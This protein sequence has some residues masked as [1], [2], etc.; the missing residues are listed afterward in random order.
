MSVHAPSTKVV[1]RVGDIVGPL[2][3]LAALVS[4][5][6]LALALPAMKAAPHDLPV[7]IAGPAV[8]AGPVSQQLATGQPGAVSLTSFP[9]EAALRSAITHREVYGGLLLSPAGPKLLVASAASPTVAI[10]LQSL[11]QGIAQAQGAQLTV[12]DVVPLPADDPHGA[13]L[14]AALLPMLIGAV[15]TVAVSIRIVRGPVIRI[16]AALAANLAVGFGVVAVL[17]FGLGALTGS[18]PAESLTL[19][20]TLAA[21]SMVL[22]GLFGLIRWP[23]VGLGVLTMLLLGMPLSGVQGAPELLPH[24]WAT[25]GQ[26]LPPGAGG[27]ALRSVAYFDGHGALAALTVLGCWAA[28]GL[29]L[30]VGT[31]RLHRNRNP[32]ID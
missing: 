22:L 31:V 13:G 16:V 26:L 12:E 19:S 3:A 9:D 8:A 20:L 7:G 28:A 10:A 11:G 24:R 1:G 32:T 29:V 18:Y 23:G 6:A 15:A 14:A 17:H 21:I 25:L 4:L 5:L 27:T 30:A 2:I